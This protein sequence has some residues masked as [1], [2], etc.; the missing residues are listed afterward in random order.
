MKIIED[1]I[2]EMIHKNL[3]K[4]SFKHSYGKI[5]LQKTDQLN[6]QITIISIP[7][8]SSRIP[9]SDRLTCDIQG[10]IDFAIQKILNDKCAKMR[11]LKNYDKRIL[12]VDNHYMFTT[13]ENVNKSLRKFKSIIKV[14]DEIWILS[15]REIYRVY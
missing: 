2:L 1:R 4:S 6:N 13:K 9:L 14:I 15:R 8:P 12:L 3:D 7:S 5:Y 10:Q 11:K